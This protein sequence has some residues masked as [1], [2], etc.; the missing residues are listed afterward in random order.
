MDPLDRF[1]ILSSACDDTKVVWLPP[2]SLVERRYHVLVASCFVEMAVWLVGDDVM[3]VDHCEDVVGLVACVANDGDGVDDE[4]VVVASCEMVALVAV[5]DL[6][7]VLAFCSLESL[8]GL[9]EGV[10]LQMA[11]HLSV[12]A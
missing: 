2:L 8:A 4:D 5:L 10:A 6:D 1:H 7:I 11:C 3:A 9:V 12:E